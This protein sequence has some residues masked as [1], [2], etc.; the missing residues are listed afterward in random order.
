MFPFYEYLCNDDYKIFHVLVHEE[1]HAI[2]AVL[3]GSVSLFIKRELAG[4]CG[5]F[6]V[7]HFG[8]RAWRRLTTQ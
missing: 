4:L 7:L 1:P 2:H 6:H 8:V 5:H 3:Q